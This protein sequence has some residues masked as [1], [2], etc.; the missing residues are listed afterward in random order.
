MPDKLAD[1][2][3]EFAATYD[4]NRSVFDT[5][6]ILDAF[7]SR[8]K[9]TQGKLLDLG[10]GA[11]EP[12]SRFFVDQGWQVTGVDFSSKML[13]LANQYV[14]EMQTVHA[15]IREVVF[16]ANAFDAIT[17][18]YS[19]FHIPKTEHAQL[20]A[21]LARWLKPGGQALFTYATED[22]TGSEEFDGYKE[23]MHKQLYY[24]HNNLE[25]LHKDLALSGLMV[26][27]SDTKTIANE[28]FLWVTVRK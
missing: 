7:Y 18:I 5:R 1:T 14:P 12:F 17:A 10:C 13:E 11:G 2:Y 6:E 28:T 23:F 25:T 27:A 9:P 3:D 4:E 15:D 20:F 22:Y 8:L 26:A 16:P 21:K 24:S 19:L